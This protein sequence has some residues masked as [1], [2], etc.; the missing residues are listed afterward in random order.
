M[1]PSLAI[2]SDWIV[3]RA[4]HHDEGIAGAGFDEAKRPV[5][6]ATQDDAS[7]EGTPRRQFEDELLDL[8]LAFETASAAGQ[9]FD[10]FLRSESQKQAG[11][12]LHRFFQM[13]ACAKF[14]K[15]PEFIA[16]SSLLM[17]SKTLGEL[18]ME[19]GVSKQAIFYHRKRFQQ[20][21]LRSAHK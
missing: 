1:K 2:S 11:E 18:E 12:M 19:T 8:G 4:G 20:I 14:S 13:M 6:V 3:Q 10:D 5:P 9:I 17:P 7:D 15:T 16:L 21:F